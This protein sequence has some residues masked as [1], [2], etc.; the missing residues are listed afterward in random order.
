MSLVISNTARYREDF[1]RLQRCHDLSSRGGQSGGGPLAMSRKRPATTAP[2]AEEAE[3]DDPFRVILAL[4]QRLLQERELLTQHSQH[5]RDCLV[6]IEAM[7]RQ[8]ARVK[9]PTS[10]RRTSRTTDYGLVPALS[11]A[12]LPAATNLCGYP[13]DRDRSCAG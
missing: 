6:T 12:V 5:V 4:V 9:S 8:Y 11:S 7:Q 3:E 10:G 2:D 1:V 13:L